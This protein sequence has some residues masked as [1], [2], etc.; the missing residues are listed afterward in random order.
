MCLCDGL[1][2]CP[3]WTWAPV[4]CHNPKRKAWVK[5]AGW[6]HEMD[7]GDPAG[8][9]KKLW[10]IS[11]WEDEEESWGGWNDD[12]ATRWEYLGGCWWTVSVLQGPG[13]ALQAPYLGGLRGK[14]PVRY[15]MYNWCEV[16]L[17][18]GVCRATW[19]DEEEKRRAATEGTGEIER[20]DKLWKGHYGCFCWIYYFMKAGHM[21]STNVPAGAFRL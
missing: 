11:P 13:G 15:C 17:N 12:E 20:R 8:E 21:R 5:E 18:R 7:E 16:M 6:T 9:V 14:K 1:V 19:E 3:E 10:M 2:T 4:T